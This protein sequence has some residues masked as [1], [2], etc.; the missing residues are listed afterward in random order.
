MG[1][2]DLDLE[3]LLAH[4]LEG[5]TGALSVR[6]GDEQIE[7]G[8]GRFPIY[9]LAKTIIAALLVQSNDEGQLGLDDP[10]ARWHPEVP[11][12][13][14]MSLR[15][16]LQH[17]AG[18]RDYGSLPEYHAALASTPGQAWG[19]TAF[20]DHTW[21][22]G[23]VHEAG[24]RFLYSNPGYRLL[25]EVVEQVAD[26]GF[27]DLVE[28]R[29]A[30]PLG[31]TRTFVLETHA[32][33]AELVPASTSRLTQDASPRD[34]GESMD[35]GWVFHGTLASTAGEVLRFLAALAGGSLVSSEG[36]AEMTR[37]LP[38]DESAKGWTVPAYGLGLMGDIG[39]TFGPCW[40]H[41]GGGP[42]YTASA[43]H[44]PVQATTVCV[45]CADERD[46]AAERVLRCVLEA[47]H[48]PEPQASG[49][50][51]TLR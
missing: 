29:I 49:I 32:H 39:S 1:L 37:L 2:A 45:L 20:A 47:L 33:Y 36:L 14:E 18:L 10:L 50:S 42:G 21:M 6:V 51:S 22:K 40:G 15:H 24:E 26:A 38:I 27:E 35:P 44:F 46:G 23:P 8:G 43:F 3:V 41:N 12:A 30:R 5:R 19:R 7:A 28:A 16:V 34:V 31:L 11:G 25:R 17:R 9:S 48:S 13:S 4:E